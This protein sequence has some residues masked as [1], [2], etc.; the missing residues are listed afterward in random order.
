VSNNAEQGARPTIHVVAAALY[1]SQGRVLIA[2]RPPGK[3]LSGRWEFP[4]GKVGENETPEAALIR[5]LKE[6]LGIDVAQRTIDAKART[7]GGTG[8]LGADPVVN[9]TPMGI[10]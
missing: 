6:E 7:L 5:E 3:Y 2:E 8:D 1:D 10:P 4:G 9:P